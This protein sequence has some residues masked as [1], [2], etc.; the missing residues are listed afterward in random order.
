MEV[1]GREPW[2]LS[3]LG[4][5]RGPDAGE[6]STSSYKF[7]SAKVIFCVCLCCVAASGLLFQIR[8]SRTPRPVRAIATTIPPAQAHK[9]HVVHSANAPHLPALSGR[10]PRNGRWPKVMTESEVEALCRCAA[11]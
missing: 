1:E 4:R 8:T 3:Y 5:G 2:S 9:T 7:Y 10:A 11:I 6:R